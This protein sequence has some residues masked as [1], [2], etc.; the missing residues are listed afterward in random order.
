[1]D[2]TLLTDVSNAAQTNPTIRRELRELS[3]LTRQIDAIADA[4][5]RK[6]NWMSTEELVRR[7]ESGTGM[8]SESKERIA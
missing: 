5:T 1:M 8:G 7:A 3:R 6:L 2:S 4:E